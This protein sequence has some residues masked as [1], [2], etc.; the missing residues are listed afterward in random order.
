MKT[1]LNLLPEEKKELVQSRLRFRFL[2]WQFFLFLLLELF[3][4]SILVGMYLILDFQIKTLQTMLGNN[5]EVAELSQEK[6]LSSFEKKFHEI[7]EKADKVGK[8]ELSHLHFTRMFLLLDTLMPEGVSVSNIVTNE[9]TV[10]VS[11]KAKQRENLLQF[12][13]NLKESDCTANVN[14]PLSNLFS[15]ENIDFQIDFKMKP[16]CLKE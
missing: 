12:D 3:Y 7:N 6:K 16:E 5:S 2:L 1:L 8:I 10:S 15:Q 9:Y 11:G 4:F 14:V 13:G